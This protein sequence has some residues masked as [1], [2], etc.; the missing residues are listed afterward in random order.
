MDRLDQEFPLSYSPPPAQTQPS[1]TTVSDLSSVASEVQRLTRE[2]SQ[3][4][5]HLS[6]TFYKNSFWVKAH[7]L[8]Y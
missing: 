4:K 3:R 8:T 5:S 2:L 6:S 7:N 1:G